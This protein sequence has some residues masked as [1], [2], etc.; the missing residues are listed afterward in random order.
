[1]NVDARGPLI[2]GLAVGVGFMIVFSIA[3]NGLY[4]RPP[5]MFLIVE[6]KRF[7]AGYG[8]YGGIRWDGTHFGAD[9]DWSR[10]LPEGTINATRGSEIQFLSP[11]HV[12][13]VFSSAHLYGEGLHN[14]FML[15]KVND[16]TFRITDEVT[17]GDYIITVLVQYRDS[18]IASSSYIHKIRIS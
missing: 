11:G 2:A 5:D 16:N 3:V 10:T 18:M 6:G 17:K 1:M 4:P 15:E 9:V 8:S 13:P 7:K 12:R 14:L